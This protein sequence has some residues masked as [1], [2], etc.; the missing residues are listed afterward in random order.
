MDGDKPWKAKWGA[1]WGRLCWRWDALW[2]HQL[3]ERAGPK[4][5][6][7]HVLAEV[8]K[9]KKK[10]VL[11]ILSRKKMLALLKTSASSW[12]RSYQVKR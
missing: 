5:A 2:Q 9:K 3:W 1:G 12:D 8:L 4:G 10:V 7:G 6:P 11:I